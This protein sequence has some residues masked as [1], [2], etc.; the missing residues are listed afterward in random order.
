MAQAY[1]CDNC[2]QLVEGKPERDKDLPV[3]DF[4]MRFALAKKVE[5]EPKKD[6]NP[7]AKALGYDD[8]DDGLRATDLC[9]S[10]LDEVLQLALIQ[11]QAVA[12][13]GERVST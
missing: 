1:K 11:V 12:I 10:C 6:M 9:P 3:G 4:I 8:E 2:N 5:P 13:T 7:I